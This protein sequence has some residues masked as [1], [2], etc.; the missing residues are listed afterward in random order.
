MTETAIV[1]PEEAKELA[2]EIAPVVQRARSIVVKTAEDRTFAVEFGRQL[3]DAESKITAFWKPIKDSTNKAHKDAVAGEKQF[4][5]PVQ[6]AVNTVKGKILAYDREEEAKREAERRR[7]QAI[8][9]EQARKERERLEREAAKL[10]TPELKQAR[11]EEAQAVA[12]PVVDIPAPEKDQ[13]ASTRKL[14]RGKCEDMTALAKAASEGNQVAQSF[15]ALDK[16]AVNKFASATKGAVDVPGIKFYAE[17]S[18]ALG[19]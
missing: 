15:L 17:D 12:A 14:W 8:A 11:I 5:T 16:S 7:L 10:K 13:G 1:M 6:T 9:D 19:R 3:K 4:L 18:L 2:N